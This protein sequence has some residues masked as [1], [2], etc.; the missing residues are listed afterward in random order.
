MVR[1]PCP[2]IVPSA[3]NVRL[4]QL[5]HL[6]RSGGVTVLSAT[7]TKPTKCHCLDNSVGGGVGVGEG[8]V[9]VGGSLPHPAASRNRAVIHK[10]YFAFI[11]IM[12]SVNYKL[13]IRIDLSRCA[14]GV[15]ILR[16]P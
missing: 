13:R 9:G 10:M 3:P 12:F 4:K 2:L 6:I 16:A 15:R 7:W 11:F 1:K 14:S 5:L 8:G